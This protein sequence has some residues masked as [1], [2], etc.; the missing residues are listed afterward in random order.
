MP[1]QN[2]NK[3]PEKDVGRPDLL[4]SRDASGNIRARHRGRAYNQSILLFTSPFA[5]I[6]VHS[7]LITASPGGLARTV[8]GNGSTL[9]S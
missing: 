7:R 8:L 5:S 3:P 2:Q 4:K 9:N 1:L 6:R